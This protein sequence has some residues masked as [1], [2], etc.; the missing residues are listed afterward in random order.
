MQKFFATE[1]KKLTAL[2]NIFLTSFF[3]RN[4][5]SAQLLATN[6][7]GS[8]TS[9]NF[10]ARVPTVFIAHGYL[11]NENANLNPLIRDGN[12]LQCIMSYIGYG[13]SFIL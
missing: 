1:Y 11:G 6:N 3:R 2:S 12:L 9:S 8:I 5:T 4:P 13:S 7:A 10:N